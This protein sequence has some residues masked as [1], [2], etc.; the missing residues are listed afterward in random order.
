METVV[1]R[2]FLL[3]D[4]FPDALRIDRR[5]DSTPR[6]GGISPPFDSWSVDLGGFKERFTRE[7][8]DG[9]LDESGVLRSK[10]DVPFFFNHDSNL[11]TGRTA[12]GRLEVRRE[13]K[14]LGYL[15][16]PLLTTHGRDLVMMIDDRTVKAASFAFT[17]HPKGD[18]W[19]EDERGN[20]TRTVTRVDGLYDISAVVNPAYPKSSAS[21]RSLEQWRQAR[22]LVAGRGEGGKPLTIAIDYDATFVAA[23]GLWRSLIADATR[24]GDEVVLVSSGI[25]DRVEADLREAADDLTF[26]TVFTANGMRRREACRAAGVEP[27]AWVLAGGQEEPEAPVK[28]S[29]LIGARAAAAAAAARMRTTLGG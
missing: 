3:V 7:S 14:G 27:D 21:P 16:T 11:V 23:P 1:E 18:L 24:R 5:E 19:E 25:R 26:R 2:R 9:L 29:T 12:N 10:W 8:F 20:I 28:V 22:G 6:I 4:D 15:H 17:T 13:D